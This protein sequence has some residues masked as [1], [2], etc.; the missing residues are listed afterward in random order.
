[1]QQ[2][3]VQGSKET[4]LTRIGVTRRD[5]WHALA[6]SPF[7]TTL[8]RRPRVQSRSSWRRGWV[9]VDV[10]RRGDSKKATPAL[11]AH[12]YLLRKSRA[13]TP[14][15]G[16]FWLVGYH[17]CCAMSGKIKSRSAANAESISGGVS[18][19]ERILRDCHQLYT[20]ADSGE[21]A[22]TPDIPGNSP[23]VTF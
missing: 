11:F 4:P 7:K 18:C 19:D 3:T 23:N 5:P 16:S 22:G 15:H 14:Y 17:R 12:V 8:P 21:L 20:D 9:D 10:S 6:P 2:S 13:F 1:M